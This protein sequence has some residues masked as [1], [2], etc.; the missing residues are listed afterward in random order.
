M[1]AS[2]LLILSAMAYHAAAAEITAGYF[3]GQNNLNNTF[4][5]LGDL[6]NQE[7]CTSHFDISGPVFNEVPS[8]IFFQPYGPPGTLVN[9]AQL[10]N[11]LFQGFEGGQAS[12]TI[13]GVY[14]PH[15]YL[16]DYNYSENEPPYPPYTWITFGGPQVPIR[17]PV[18]N[19]PFTAGGQLSIYLSSAA[20][21]AGD[22]FICTT[23]QGSGIETVYVTPGDLTPGDGGHHANF[24]VPPLTFE[25]EP[26]ELST[27]TAP[28]PSTLGLALIGLAGAIRLFRKKARKPRALI[29]PGSKR[30]CVRT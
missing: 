16:G 22:C 20:Y 24:L 12:G 10:G 13:N 1:K 17:E 8:P 2:F 25:F 5:V 3:V 15:L 18:F 23:W 4:H 29:E 6:C 21:T 9:P 28:E 11:W 19:A 14:Y 30:S 7:P 27:D 26:P